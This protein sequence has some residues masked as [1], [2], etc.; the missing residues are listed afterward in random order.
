MS[1]Q[2]LKSKLAIPALPPGLVER[3]HLLGL[4]DQG[5]SKK[6]TLVSAPA[7]YGKTTLLSAWA[8]QSKIPVGWLS[9]DEGD[10]DLSRFTSYLSASL[11]GIFPDLVSLNLA[12]LESAGSASPISIEN[13]SDFQA[14]FLNQVYTLP[15]DFA[16]VLDDFHVIHHPH[17]LQLVQSLLDHLPPQMH[18]VLATR[19]D[20]AFPL[21]RLRARNQLVEIRLNE[22]RFSLEEV[23]TFLNRS[24]GL[25]LSAQ[26][27]AALNERAEGWPA[28][29]QM[30]ALAMQ[31]YSRQGAGELERY[32]RAFTGSSRY[33]LD[34]LVE[35]VL[36]RQSEEVQEFL[37]STSI[38]DRLTASLCDELLKD[39]PGESSQDLRGG[40]T[41]GDE[42]DSFIPGDP[43]ALDSS[44]SPVG[45]SSF[46]LGFLER[47]NLFLIPLDETRTW[48]RYHHLFADL[49]RRQ[50]RNT[51]PGRIPG[52][53][54]RA[55]R[56]FERSG[57]VEPAIEHAF[58]AGEIDRAA[59]LLEV[60]AVDFL[61]RG[62][63]ATLLGWLRALPERVAHTR[64]LLE[65]Y[66]LTCLIL[67]GEAPGSIEKELEQLALKSGMTAEV[68]VLRAYLAVLQTQVQTAER[69]VR[70]A[71]AVLPASSDFYR[72]MAAWVE[73]YCQTSEIGLNERVESLE[74]LLRSSATIENRM[75]WVN[76]L[77]RLAETRT[78]QGNLPLA[79]D[80]YRKAIDGAVGADG[81]RLAVAGEA[82]IGLGHILREWNDLDTAG[83]MIEEGIR[84]IIQVRRLG[85]IEGWIALAFCRLAQGDSPAVHEAIRQARQEA[86]ALET[87][88][89]DD[90]MV[91]F[92]EAL[93]LQKQ[94]DNQAILRYFEDK[95]ARAKIT[96]ADQT[97]GP[98]PQGLAWLDAHLRKYEQVA[99]ARAFLAQENAQAALAVLDAIRPEMIR[100]DRVM[101][102]IEIEL[103]RALALQKLGD[104]EEA[105]STFEYALTKAEPG[106]WVRMFV[107][108]GPVMISFLEKAAARKVCPDYT[109]RLLEALP[110]DQPG[111]PVRRPSRP[112]V[113]LVEPLSQRELEVLRLLAGNLPAKEIASL[114]SVAE[115]TLNS[116]VKSIYG[117]LGVHR[118]LDA[119]QRAK[120]LDLL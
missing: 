12:Q 68:D 76:A 82:M 57:M 88:E 14:A 13:L 118:R 43:S 25:D 79:R 103:L 61:R 34:Y 96:S 47:S 30:A 93:V 81:R 100:Q 8:R 56:W 104:T 15:G 85:A 35:E 5:V 117:K 115:S 111:Q 84:L 33:I 52:L 72:G 51:A 19:A 89:I 55:S 109:A 102:V 90:R 26:D 1:I 92:Y 9:L 21:P 20:P 2:L 66:R 42:K 73:N 24:N 114:L 94:G 87:T 59:D 3:A 48:Y 60:E 11:Q 37:L 41:Y 112:A 86:R 6:L 69:L 17:V 40:R 113:G 98:G 74:S 10:N 4:L 70:G 120:E 78:R 64:P 46:L 62:E 7:G 97:Q 44:F 27:L 91:N 28:G 101:L 108:E 53:H 32:V 83:A 67:I 18:L 36:D 75:M 31:G 65:L 116:H 71:L 110:G 54:L 29:L 107:D 49:L 77:C 80:H 38:L 58:A 23:T 50:L 106:G 105:Q 45:P 22:L 99:H 39:D 63:T 95:L 119:A 16:L